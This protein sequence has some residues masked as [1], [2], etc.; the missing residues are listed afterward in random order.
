LGIVLA[1]K[2]EDIVLAIFLRTVAK[3]KERVVMKANKVR[4]RLAKIEAMI[5]DLTERYSKG[6]FHI[7]EALHNAKVAVAHAKEAVLSQVSSEKAKRS[8]VKRKKAAVK[9]AAV[10]TPTAKAAKKSAPIKKPVKTAAA[11]KTAPAP[12]QAGTKSAAQVPIGK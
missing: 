7:R 3:L 2:S 10:K 4:K 11:K 1:L 8:P 6:A 12:V 9:K 5:S